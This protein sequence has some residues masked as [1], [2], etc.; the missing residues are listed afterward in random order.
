MFCTN[1]GNQV[2]SEDKFCAKCG[3]GRL[4]TQSTSAIAK[5]VSSFLDFDKRFIGS[6]IIL[7][8]GIIGLLDIGNIAQNSMQGDREGL[9]TPI[10]GFMFVL[11]ASR[12]S[13]G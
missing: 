12:I 10:A 7:S 13:R 9:D 6:N 2:K 1:C 4:R 8:I 3:S 11:G 5:R